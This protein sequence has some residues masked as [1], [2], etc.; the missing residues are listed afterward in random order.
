MP[1]RHTFGESADTT[2]GADDLRAMALPIDRDPGDT[3][4]YADSVGMQLLRHASLPAPGNDEAKLQ[5]CVGHSILVTALA[6]GDAGGV[7]A[8]PGPSLAGVVVD[9]LGA[10][11]QRDTFYAALSDPA[12]HSFCGITEPRHGSDAMGMEARLTA[13]DGGYLLNGEKRYIG[14]GA[15]G[16]IGVVFARTGLSPL[17][18]RAIL[19]D[20]AASGVQ[21]T[22][23]DTVG[24]RGAQIAQ[25]TF[26]DVFV[27]SH[28]VLGQHLPVTRRGVWGAVQ[29]FNIMRTQVAALAIGTS[30]AIV[31]LVA[32]AKPALDVAFHR[33]RIDAGYALMLRGAEQAD[34]DPAVSHLASLAKLHAVELCRDLSEWAIES[35]GPSSLLEHPLLEKWWRDAYGFEFMEGVSNVQRIHIAQ[36]FAQRCA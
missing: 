12:A 32:A 8:A 30:A 23:I 28:A 11:Q 25:L 20:P 16:K 18:I 34:Q 14:N 29:A 13:T 4:G 6:Y 31:D 17:T 7:L 2:R 9:L 10:P 22:P 26:S 5:G 15:R 3:S 33:A 24:L 21:R 1:A 35:L 27:P 36:E 19:L